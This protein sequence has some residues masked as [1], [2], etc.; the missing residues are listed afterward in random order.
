MDKSMGL[1]LE[2]HV[3]RSMGLCRELRRDRSKQL[4]RELRRDRSKRLR[5][6]AHLDPGRGTSKSAR[7]AKVAPLVEV[8]KVKVATLVEEGT[9]QE[10]EQQSTPALVTARSI[11][12]ITHEQGCSDGVPNMPAFINKSMYNRILIVLF[13]D[14][15]RVN[16]GDKKTKAASFCGEIGF[17]T[18]RRVQRRRRNGMARIVTTSGVCYITTYQTISRE[19]GCI[20]SMLDFLDLPPLEERRRQLRLSMLYKIAKGLVPA[21]LTDA[22]LTAANRNRPTRGDG[23]LVVGSAEIEGAR[24]PI[25]L[26]K[27]LKETRQGASADLDLC[28]AFTIDEMQ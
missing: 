22:F 6:E 2:V 23:T 28:D 7:K 18:E 16:V 1:C 27:E 19:P 21:L 3:D 17:T 5:R 15:E 11:Q 9:R 10:D 4:H 14:D 20:G 26:N 24:C 8:T 12:L 25:L 13:C